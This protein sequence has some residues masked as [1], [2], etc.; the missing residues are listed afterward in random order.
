MS[1]V[2][3]AMR[4]GARIFTVYNLNPA[5]RW[6]VGVSLKN[7]LCARNETT[8]PGGSTVELNPGTEYDAVDLD[9]IILMIFCTWLMFDLIHS[10][11][12]IWL[13]CMLQY[14]S[15]FV[16][17]LKI[18]NSHH[19]FLFSQILVKFVKFNES[20][21]Q[22]MNTWLYFFQLYSKGINLNLIR[23]TFI[24][25]RNRASVFTSITISF[26]VSVL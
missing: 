1:A 10:Q 22:S 14:I 24:R 17:C 2:F 16:V 26:S 11:I 21:F 9:Y 6:P 25:L 20:L 3:T 15:N 8:K 19:S 23:R 12:S 18:P 13:K 4:T 7:Q 5:A